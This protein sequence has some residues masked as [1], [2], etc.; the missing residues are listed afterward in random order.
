MR[1]TH[2]PTRPI[3]K[4]TR[5]PSSIPQARLY[6]GANLWS[7]S[8]DNALDQLDNMQTIAWTPDHLVPRKSKL[9]NTIMRYRYKRN[10][11]GYI[12]TRKARY[13]LRGELMLPHVHFDPT[14]VATFMAEKTI[15]L[16]LFALAAQRNLHLEHFHITCAYLHERYNHDRPSLFENHCALKARTSICQPRAGSWVTFTVPL[17]QRSY[18]SLECTPTSSTT[19]SSNSNLT[20]ASSLSEHQLNS[21]SLR[22]AWMTF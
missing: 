22:Q 17:L 7:K 8:H 9:V 6:P 15:V 19:I 4:H 3:T 12:A 16:F 18:T 5:P 20:P 11:E 14:R 21:P 13:S 10:F 1:L 2:P